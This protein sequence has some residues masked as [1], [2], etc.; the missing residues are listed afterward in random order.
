MVLIY[1]NF[2]MKIH[3]FQASG[4]DPNLPKF[5]QAKITKSTVLGDSNFKKLVST[6]CAL[7]LFNDVC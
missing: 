3:E 7:C 1:A 5:K 6:S 4:K 2:V